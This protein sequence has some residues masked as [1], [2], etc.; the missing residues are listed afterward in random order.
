MSI[1]I[2]NLVEKIEANSSVSIQEAAKMASSSSDVDQPVVSVADIAS[3]PDATLNKGRM[4]Y[5][6]D[7]CS[8]RFSDGADWVQDYDTVAKRQLYAIGGNST[9]GRLGI[10]DT[11]DRSVPTIIAGGGINWSIVGNCSAIKTDGTL[12]TWGNNGF[13]EIG[14]GTLDPRSSPVNIPGTNWCLANKNLS[15]LAIKTDGT[16][17]TWGYG[18][19][20]QLGDDS[21]IDKCSP[22][23]TVGGGTNWCTGISA[24]CSMSAIKTDGTLWTWGTN[25]YG[26][27]GSDL[28]SDMSS[29]VTTAG[30]GTNW[31][32]VTGGYK[33]FGAIKTDGT[34]WNWGR[35][36]FGSLGIND[37]ASWAD[38]PVTTAGGGTNWCKI[39][40]NNSTTFGLKTDG[41][42][43]G[44]GDNYDYNL[45]DGSRSD[46]SSPVTTVTG[47]TDWA[48][49]GC[50]NSNYV[51]AGGAIKTDGS[52]WLWGSDS[53]ILRSSSKVT[54]PTRYGGLYKEFA[55]GPGTL[56]YILCTGF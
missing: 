38:S 21:A 32:S 11:E 47:G 52:L 20:G 27:L 5:V 26:Q 42:L 1:G 37:A 23:T 6:N 17:W 19:Y 35:N 40:K 22:V 46:R 25:Q 29:P 28:Y 9:S 43:W 50:G 36:Q 7:S 51:P 45:G 4:I 41:T 12:W 34:L 3:L 48:K 49:L 30:G 8:Y 31:C 44:W 14:D 55:F 24:D 33:S 16:L 15:T 13:G 56:H 39:T 18:S 10:S 53:L 2:K 54:Q